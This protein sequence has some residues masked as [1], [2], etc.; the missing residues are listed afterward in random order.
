KLA[1]LSQDE[2]AER[3]GLSSRTIRNLES[4]RTSSPYRDTL[5]RLADALELSG[6]ARIEFIGTPDRRLTSRDECA[7]EADEAGTRACGSDA[8]SRDWSPAVPRQ[9]PGEARR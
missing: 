3:S 7:P 9:L 5:R 8:D 6:A 1:G 2:L 4:G